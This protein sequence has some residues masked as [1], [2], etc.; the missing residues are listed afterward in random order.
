MRTITVIWV[1]LFFTSIVACTS[2]SGKNLSLKKGSIVK[3]KVIAV[4]DGDT[5]DVLLQG[6]KTVRVRMEGI[7]APER[8]M[9]FYQ[10]SKKYLSD[11]CL[12]KQIKIK[13]TGV[14]NHERFLAYSYLEDDK[15]LSQEMIKAGLAW[16]FKKYNSD[17]GLSELEHEAKTLGKGLWMDENPM[18]PWENRNLHRNGISTKDSFNIEENNR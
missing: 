4:I 13:I 11:L 16:H 2:K 15:E 12:G 1:I 14:D 3:G 5:Y 9:P 7:D 10:K 17:S 18:P 8:G 6:N